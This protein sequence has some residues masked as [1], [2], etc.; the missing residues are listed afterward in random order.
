[1]AAP[2]LAT[3]TGVSTRILAEPGMATLRGAGICALRALAQP[4]PA[5]V[6]NSVAP[7]ADQKISQRYAEY[8]RLRARQVREM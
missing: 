4:I 2:I 3:V 5:I 8:R 1:M 6:L 7:I